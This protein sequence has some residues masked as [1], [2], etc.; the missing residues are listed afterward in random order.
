M[1]RMRRKVQPETIIKK[2]VRLYLHYKGWFSFP[3]LQG[4]GA[5]KGI[6]DLIAVKNGQV[7]FI[8]VKRPDGRLSDYQKRFKENIENAGCKYIVA[9]SAEELKDVT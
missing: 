1:L 6:P 8:E 9:R 2:S 4:L 7:L 5:Y 3:I